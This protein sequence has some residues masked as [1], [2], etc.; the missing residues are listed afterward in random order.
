MSIV[1]VEIRPFGPGTTGWTAADLDDP[2]I[3]R[4]WF[5]GRYEIVEGVLTEMPAAYFAGG[6]SLSNLIYLMRI[7]GVKARFATEVDIV[8]SARRVARS[9][10]AALL[11]A[12]SQ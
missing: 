4:Q 5:R 3:E 10:A 9:D 7:Q 6:E 1:D 2:E 12:E 8:V 11:P